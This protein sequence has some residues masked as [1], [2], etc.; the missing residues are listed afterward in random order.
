MK[1]IKENIHTIILLIGFGLIVYG[2]FLIGQIVGFIGSGVLAV[3]LAL[4][5]DNSFM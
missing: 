2:L 4:L 1:F 3:L 5:I